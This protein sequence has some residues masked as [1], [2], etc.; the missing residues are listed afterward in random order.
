MP[1]NLNA[2]I[3]FFLLV[4]GLLSCKKDEKSAVEQVVASNQPTTECTMALANSFPELIELPPL[5]DNGAYDP[6]IAGDPLSGKLWMVF[7]RVEGLGG[8]GKVSTHLA[9][10]DNNGSSWCYA[11][12]INSSEDVAIADLPSEYSGAISAHWSHEVPSIAYDPNAPI[13]K[14]WIMTWHRYLHVDNGVAGEDQRRFAY[15]WIASKTASSPSEFATMPEVKLFSAAGYYSTMAVKN[16]NDQIGGNPLVRF[17]QIHPDLSTAVVLTETGMHSYKGFLYMSLVMGNPSG[18]KVV[19]IKYS[20][21]QWQYVST[22]LTPADAQAI[23]SMWTGFSATD[24]FVKNDQ[25]YLIV[26][27][28]ANLYEGL[29][30]FQLN[31]PS[32][33]LVDL[34]SNGPDVIWSLA[35]TAGSDV[36]QTGVG[37]YDELSYNT[38]I[39]YGD[40]VNGQPQFRIFASGY[41]PTN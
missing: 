16:Y 32:G 30:L 20:N 29:L 9:Y 36:I 33:T 28:V 11:N 19:L 2:Y 5:G 25:P 10:S 6:T 15:G 35:K 12:Q 18:N 3:L 22:L 13:T 34:D 24:I 38:G 4:V 31:L 41:I 27:P 40:A 7:S 21:G 1:Q 26:S 8:V 39:I 23:N 37:T 14:R 17:D